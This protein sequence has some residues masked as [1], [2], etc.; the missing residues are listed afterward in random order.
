MPHA[1]VANAYVVRRRTNCGRLGAQD[2]LGQ[3]KKAGSAMGDAQNDVVLQVAAASEAGVLA[4]LLQLYIY[5]LSDVFAL[6]PGADGRFVYDQLPAYWSEPERR[7][8]L[9]IRCGGKLAGF[10]LITRGSPVTDDPEFDMAEFFVL[11][12]YRRGGIGR[13]AAMLLWD[14]FAAPW[15][16]R[17]SEGNHAGCRFWSDVIGEYT[18]GAMT[19]ATREG[20]PHPWRVFR[21]D[22]R[23]ARATDDG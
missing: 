10:A 7:F 1:R 4:N 23:R 21:F 20:R 19:Q 16:I 12:R 15:T 14:R 22:S 13:R 2:W 5:D 18:N 6:D 9:L 3:N 11:R 17:V 8:P